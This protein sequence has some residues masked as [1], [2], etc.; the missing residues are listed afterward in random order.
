LE[1]RI[2]SQAE[3]VRILTHP[4]RLHLALR[5]RITQQ[6]DGNVALAEKGGNFR[7]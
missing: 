5:D 2:V 6:A 3:E 7:A 4:H 1:R